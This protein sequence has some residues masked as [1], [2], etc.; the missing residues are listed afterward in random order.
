M[1]SIKRF[2]SHVMSLFLLPETRLIHNNKPRGATNYK[3]VDTWDSQETYGPMTHFP[4]YGL[5]G[6][7]IDALR[8][9]LSRDDTDHRNRFNTV[10]S[11]MVWKLD[12][13]HIIGSGDFS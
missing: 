6:C 12:S 5:T 13:N 9:P 10:R 4:K 1:G 11:V 3:S 8:G 7:G 2:L